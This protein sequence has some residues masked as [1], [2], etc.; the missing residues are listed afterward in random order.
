MADIFLRKTLSGYIPADAAS[1]AEWR[2][3]KAGEVYRA[4]VTKPRN[5]KHHCLF[6][7]LLELTF[8]NQ[9]KWP[10]ERQF[11]RAVALEAGHV[12]EIMTVD[13]VI[14]KV[15]LSY[16]YDEL[17]DEDDFDKEFGAAMAVCAGILRMTAPDLE[18]EVL[19]YA[20]QRMVA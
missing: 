4:K 1:E 15:P 3:Q 17:P 16:S 18:A 19:R 13:G 9:E 8:N 10:N 5:Y 7:C 2:K 20:D 12:Q 11:R 6:M 14:Y